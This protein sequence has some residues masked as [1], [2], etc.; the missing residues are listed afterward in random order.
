MNT[1]TNIV[2][3]DYNIGENADGLVIERYQAI[4]ND[5]M[6]TLKAERDA[7]RNSAAGEMH[8]VA[9]I[10]VVVIDKWKREGFD[11]DNAP[12]KDILLKL[13]AEHLDG[14]ITSDKAF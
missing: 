5:F 1:K 13:K 3:S 12:V 4:P 8:R 14:F 7:N 9:S 11:F 10:P 2:D 6:A